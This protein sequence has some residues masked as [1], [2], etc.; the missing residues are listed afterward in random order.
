M[1]SF[2]GDPHCEFGEKDVLRLQ[3]I[4]VSRKLAREGFWLDILEAWT[5]GNGETETTKRQ[6]PAS[7]AGIE[8]CSSEIC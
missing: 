2:V 6:G 5:M 4:V 7:L 8:Y 1:D 3:W